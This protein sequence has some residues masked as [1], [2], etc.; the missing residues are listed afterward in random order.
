MLRP[1]STIS[2][3]WELSRDDGFAA[4]RVGVIG[5][6]HGNEIAGLRAIERV[7]NE[8][9]AFARRLKQG[10]LVLIHGNPRATLERRRHTEDGTDINRLF[11]YRWLEELARAAWTY[12]H[13]RAFELR[14]LVT[15]LDALIDLHSATRPTLPFAICDGTLAGIELARHTGCRVTYGWDGPG[16][17]ME[18][19]SIGSLVAQGK[20]ALSIECGQHEDPN[21][22][23]VAYEVLTRF[24]GALG[25]TDH[26]LSDALGPKYRLFARVVKP[27][28]GF[29]LSAAY[30]SFDRLEAG[31][32]L[33]KGDGVMIA[34]DEEAYLLLPT[35]QATRGEDIVYLARRER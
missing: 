23:L 12:E 6:L 32:V 9:D 30:Q 11:G 26:P 1:H 22:P 17:L 25:I 3:V 5:A 14:P 15:G 16:M 18:H 13:E 2:N 24:L 31:S 34:V 29:E 10:T 4:P 7:R 27:T 33:G 19:V 8:A 21:T 28:H 20:P 35:P